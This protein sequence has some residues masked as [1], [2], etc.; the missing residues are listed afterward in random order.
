MA[1]ALRVAFQPLERVIPIVPSGRVMVLIVRSS[2]F[3]AACSVG[4]APRLWVALR[5]LAFNYSIMFV[6]YSTR[7]ISNGYARNGVNSSQ[8]ARQVRT[9]AAESFFAAVKNERYHRE[10]LRTRALARFAVADYIE[11]PATA[12]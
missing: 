6:V 9:V 7:R 12:V 8:A 10:P 5:S 1:S 4:N 2:V 3:S 11:T